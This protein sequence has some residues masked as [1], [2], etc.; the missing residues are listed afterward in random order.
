M[1][2]DPATGAVDPSLTPLPG[3]PALRRF[4]I[5][6]GRLAWVSPP[7]QDGQESSVRVLG[8]AGREFGAI[9]TIPARDLFIVR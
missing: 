7:G 2:I 9:K 4:S 8:W 5:D 1:V 3:S 6:T